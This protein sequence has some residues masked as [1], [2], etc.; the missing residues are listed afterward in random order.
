MAFDPK[1][2]LRSRMAACPEIFPEYQN[3]LL[4]QKQLELAELER[5][6]RQLQIELLRK[7][8]TENGPPEVEELPPWRADGLDTDA[9]L[10]EYIQHH[11]ETVLAGWSAE[12]YG[13][14]IRRGKKV[15]SQ[16]PTYR[17][18]LAG[19]EA[20]K[21]QRKRDVEFGEVG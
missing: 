7:Q 14:E 10:I 15:T 19:R 16:T 17:K 13:R 18:I 4:K 2:L 20:E 3:Q 11:P 12:R 5:E 21:L 9:R 1:S 6:E 8:L